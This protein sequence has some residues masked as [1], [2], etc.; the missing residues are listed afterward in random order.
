MYIYLCVCVSE[1]V[2]AAVFTRV[3]LW[4]MDTGM[5]SNKKWDPTTLDSTYMFLSNPGDMYMWFN[6]QNLVILSTYTCD[7]VH[8]ISQVFEL[9]AFIASVTIPLH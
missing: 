2:S 9:W 8:N 3:S 5:M 4:E 1:F 6:A 7:L